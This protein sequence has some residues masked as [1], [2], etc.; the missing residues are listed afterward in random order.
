MS[1]GAQEA[2]TGVVYALIDP[3]TDEV[4]YIGLTV[5]KP[6]GRLA[7]HL[8]QARRGNRRHVYNWIRSLLSEGLEPDQLILYDNVPVTDLPTLE[9]KAISQARRQG[10]RL[11]N[12]TDGGEGLRN[13]STETR[14]KLSERQ[15]GKKNHNFGKNLSSTNKHRISASLR[16]NKNALGTTPSEETRAKLSDSTRGERHPRAKLTEVQ[17]REILSLKGSGRTQTSIALQYGISP[18]AVWSI[19]SGKRWPHLHPSNDNR[20]A[21]PEES[22]GS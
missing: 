6:Q 8:G 19:L 20:E 5:M 4:R 14:A 11:T 3:R 1:E 21:R 2:R 16:G 12:G 10:A 22:T 15:R 18:A 17:A 13:P 7:D 9:M